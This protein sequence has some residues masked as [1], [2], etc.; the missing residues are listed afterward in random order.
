VVAVEVAAAVRADQEVMLAMLAMLLSMLGSPLEER[1]SSVG[2]RDNRR[3]T[4]NS[5]ENK[6][7]FNSDTTP[8]IDAAVDLSE[9]NN[10]GENT[11]TLEQPITSI[12][13]ARD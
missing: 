7:E 6:N 9:T 10:D 11:G 3:S 2:D 8:K 5:I 4:G 1:L 12:K 13:K